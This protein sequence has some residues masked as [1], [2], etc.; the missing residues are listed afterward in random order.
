MKE[1]KQIIFKPF[2]F[3]CIG[4]MTRTLVSA[5]AY[6]PPGAPRDVEVTD[7]WKDGC[8]IKFKPPKNDG[9]SPIVGYRI[10]YKYTDEA[11]WD[12]LPRLILSYEI[13]VTN[14]I[15]GREVQFRV[16]AVS[17]KGGEGPPSEPTEPIVIKDR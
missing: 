17:Q 2:L 10:G 1:I 16:S 6:D 3:I 9:G 15:E 13:T 7:W 12:E 8:S 14:L 11:L 4:L 5:A